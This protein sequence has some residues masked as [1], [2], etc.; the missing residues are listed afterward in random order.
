[1]IYVD[2]KD[3]TW[4]IVDTELDSNEPF[5]KSRINIDEYLVKHASIAITNRC[6]LSCEYCYKSVKYDGCVKEIPFD[7]IKGFINDI[8]E[9]NVKG[10]KI[11]TI[12]LIGGEPTLHKDFIIIH[13][14][15]LVQQFLNTHTL[16]ADTEIFSP[17]CG[18]LPSC[19]WRFKSSGCTGT[20]CFAGIFSRMVSR[21][22]F[23]TQRSRQ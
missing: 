4:R 22:A 18:V 17:G 12:Q 1:M 8:T 19:S 5:T 6:N 11:E 13:L 9:I 15:F 14:I 16:S 10:N 2:R 7:V 20:T 23:L 21:Q 3:Y